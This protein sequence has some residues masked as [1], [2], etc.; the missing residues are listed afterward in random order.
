MFI[1][2]QSV[3]GKEF[4]FKASTSH[5]VSKASAEKIAAAL[6]RAGFM[7]PASGGLVWY[8]HDVSDYDPA[9]DYAHFQSFS[10]YRGTIKRTRR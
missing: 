7:L 2:A 4:L 5:R 1:V 8:V 6:N 9:A 10:V 3:K